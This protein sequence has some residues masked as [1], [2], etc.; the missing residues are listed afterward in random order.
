MESEL[1]AWTCK[2][3][4]QDAMNTILVIR[5]IIR[6]LAYLAKLVVR[7]IRRLPLAPRAQTRG[8]AVQPATSRRE[9]PAA[10]WQKALAVQTRRG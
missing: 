7:C 10:R 5:D 1:A 4:G 8:T 9:E 2:E 6:I 3:N